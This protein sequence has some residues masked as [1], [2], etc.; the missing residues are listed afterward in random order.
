[1]SETTGIEWCNSTWNP[2]HGC[3]KISPGCK[4]CYM[5]REKGGIVGCGSQDH[6]G[7]TWACVHKNHGEVYPACQQICG[8]STERSFMKPNDEERGCTSTPLSGALTAPL[9][10]A[11]PVMIQS[12]FATL[13]DSSGT[14]IVGGRVSIRE[15][16]SMLVTNSRWENIREQFSEAEK[17]ILRAAIHGVA[18][19]PPGVFINPD[20]LGP[21]LAAKISRALAGQPARETTQDEAL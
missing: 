20:V 1:M 7:Q 9:L 12:P 11:A 13:T 19:C 2:W 8:E 6:H 17:L 10:D 18:I 3:H 14:H 21:E 15:Q 16:K 4:N 5:F